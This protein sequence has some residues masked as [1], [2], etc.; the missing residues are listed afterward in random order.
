MALPLFLHRPT[1]RFLGLAIL[2]AFAL[3]FFGLQLLSTRSPLTLLP[4]AEHTLATAQIAALGHPTFSDIRQYEAS[5]PQHALPSVLQKTQQRYL[6]FPWEAWGTGWNNVFQEQL[7]NT[8]LAYLAGRGYVFVDYIARDHPPFP[9]TLPNGTRHMLHIPMNAFTSGP[10]G[11]GPWHFGDGSADASAP[12]GISQA[13]WDA[14][15]PPARV[16]ELNLAAT[17]AELGV[18]EG[19][20]GAERLQRWAAKLRTMEEP[21][22]SVVGGSPFDYMFVG[23]DTVVTLWPSYG[24]SPTLKAF[25]WSALIARALH[26]NFALLAPRA[27][28][29]FLSPLPFRIA[30]NAGAARGNVSAPLPL[31]LF[32]PYRA[33]EPPIGGLLG[34][35]VRR[36]DFAQHCNNLADWGSEYNTW[37]RLGYPTLHQHDSLDAMDL[38]PNS[39]THTG[40]DGPYRYPTLPDFLDVPPGTPRRDAAY[41][42]CWP[43]A[44]AIVRRVRT[45]RA[46]A[47]A[48][49]ASSSS[50]SGDARSKHYP[51]QTLS[52][53]YISTNG[54]PEWVGALADA[55]RADGW[56]R[57]ASSLDMRLEQDE[58]AVAQAVDMAVLVGAE[59]FVGVGFSSLT[60][61]V[62]QFRLAG[63]RHPQTTRFW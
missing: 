61:N 28:P 56:A 4:S 9:D 17:H 29:A 36:G 18:G 5:L 49:G 2:I 54:E 6:F 58:A 22:V 13:R 26:R 43:D 63:G 27:P 60:S 14:V 25:A 35:H 57:V 30:G 3:L 20:T 51:P 10:T 19:T 46:Q 16:V 53:V 7:L 15:C 33:V 34:I 37:A 42:H 41:A 55:L 62:V 12:R 44:A 31:A 59:A 1:T 23:S 24:A 11:G 8:H 50:P 45:V 52:T 32:V 47:A 40:T 48:G 21:C 38:P 39:D